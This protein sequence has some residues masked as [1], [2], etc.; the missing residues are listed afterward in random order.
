M[1]KFRMKPTVTVIFG[2]FVFLTFLIFTVW[3][4]LAMYS[5]ACKRQK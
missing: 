5:L 3:E 1:K 4:S 2:V